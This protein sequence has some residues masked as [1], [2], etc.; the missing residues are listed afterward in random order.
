VL[1]DYIAS[2]TEADPAPAKGQRL[3]FRRDVETE[4]YNSLPHHIPQLLRRHP[5]QCPMA[6]V[7][8]SDSLEVRQVGL[9]ATQRL[10]E[11][12]MS[13]LL[14]S[15]LFPFERPIETADEVL[16]WIDVFRTL[17]AAPDAASHEDKI[18][19]SGNALEP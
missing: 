14:G 3:T 12:R 18:T 17:A 11:G 9:A 16:R 2:G 5:L 4:I 7:Q 19:R 13:T 6:F 1:A 8:G 10:T 15:H